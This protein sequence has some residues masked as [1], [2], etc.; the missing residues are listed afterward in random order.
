MAIVHDVNAIGTELT[1]DYYV[2]HTIK[3]ELRIHCDEAGI[4][5]AVG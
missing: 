5:G 1:V 3:A 4:I 2:S